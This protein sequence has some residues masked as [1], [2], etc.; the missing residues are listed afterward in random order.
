M[1]RLNSQASTAQIEQP[2]ALPSPGLSPAAQEQ[3]VFGGIALGT[4]FAVTLL[5]HEIR[6][7][8]EAHR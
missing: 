3:L 7:L 2:A 6:L 1:S 4:I 5:I 8:V